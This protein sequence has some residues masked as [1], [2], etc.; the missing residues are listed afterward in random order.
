VSRLR[1]AVLHNRY[2]DAAPSGENVVVD[3]EIRLLREAGHD[4]IPYLR[5]SDEIATWPVSR[6]ATLPLAPIWSRQAVHDVGRLVDEHRPDVVHLHNPFPLLSPGVIDAARRRDVPV[7]QTL[8]NYRHACMK[9][10]MFRDGR[11]CEDCSGHAVQYPGV[12]H[13]CYRGSRPQSAVMAATAAVHRHRWRE[14]VARYFVLTEFLAERM[15]GHGLPAAAMVLRPHAVAD[16]GPPVPLGQGAV[17]VGR[18]DAEKGVDLLVD[19]W[20][21]AK[22]P[23]RHAQL[24]IVGDGPLRDRLDNVPGVRLAG[25]LGPDGV[26][27]ALRAAALT[28]VPSRVYEGMSMVAVESLAA[29]RPLVVTTGGPLPGV[30][31][32]AGWS[33]TATAESLTAAL[34]TALSD[35]AELERRSRLARERYCAHHTEPALVE[36]LERTYRSV[37]APEAA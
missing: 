7:V 3:Q 14:D 32:P 17:F 4:V 8:H 36:L 27:N 28:V 21:R 2:A 6:R 23:A 5:S 26:T 22:V 34:E 12:V 20:R 33:A 35:D 37:V 29:A 9:G 30:A 25:R 18:L 19:A 13:G 16:P 15:R 31:G 10:T 11:P 24:T 1:I